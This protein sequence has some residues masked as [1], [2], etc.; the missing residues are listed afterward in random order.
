MVLGK[1]RNVAMVDSL[2]VLIK[3]P[4]AKVIRAQTF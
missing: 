4:H 1:H 2:Y 3:I